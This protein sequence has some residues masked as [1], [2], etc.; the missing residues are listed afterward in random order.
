MERLI[1]EHTMNTLQGWLEDYV[2]FP[3]EAEGAYRIS[4]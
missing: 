3:T 4:G 2:V 1:L